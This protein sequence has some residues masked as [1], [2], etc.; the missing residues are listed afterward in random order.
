MLKT[1]AEMSDDELELH[2]KHCGDLMEECYRQGN[3]EA[4]HNWLQAMNKAIKARMHPI[5]TLT[6]EV[7]PAHWEPQQAAPS[8]V[9][10]ELADL[11]R[12]EFNHWITGRDVWPR[13]TH[14]EIFTAGFKAALLQASAQRE[15]PAIAK[16]DAALKACVEALET[17]SAQGLLFEFNGKIEWRIPLKA[18][19]RAHAALLEASAQREQPSDTVPVKRVLIHALSV[20]LGN[21]EKLSALAG[22]TVEDSLVELAATKLVAQREQPAEPVDMVLYCPKCGTQHIDGPDY[23]TAQDEG[24]EWMNPPHKSHLCHGCGHIWRPS[25]TP[26]NGVVRC[27]SGKD[28]DTAPATIKPEPQFKLTHIHTA[29]IDREKRDALEQ[30][31]CYGPKLFEQV[32]GFSKPEPQAQAGEPDYRRVTSVNQPGEPS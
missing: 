21:P 6:K 3:P 24:E 7:K 29:D 4:A 16:K 12:T 14:E 11:I 18:K 2:I 26:T 30:A 32:S 13:L 27:A 25:D 22:D 28:A 8:Q 5:T 10:G 31:N 9:A 15:Q 20:A 1:P 19:E 17:I 23:L